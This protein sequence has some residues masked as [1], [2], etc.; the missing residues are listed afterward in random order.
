LDE[1]S[2]TRVDSVGSR[3]LDTL[4]NTPTSRTG[5]VGSAIDFDG[6]SSIRTTDAA[7]AGFADGASDWTLS[8]WVVFDAS[9]IGA[10]RFFAA[11]WGGSGRAW[12]MEKDVGDKIKLYHSTTGSNNAGNT[13]LS[14]TPTIVA[15]T[16]YH[17]VLRHNNASNT[18]EAFF[19]GASIGTHSGDLFANGAYGVSIGALGNGTSLDGA[20]D[21]LAYWTRRLTNDEIA[22][23]YGKVQ[24]QPF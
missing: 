8:M 23:L 15:G 18:L 13:V 3:H 24:N 22:E 16:W 21:L 4:T 14:S 19:N 20:I 7:S 2:G 6:T 17:I 9:T 1:A 5:L 12:A 11:K 10:A